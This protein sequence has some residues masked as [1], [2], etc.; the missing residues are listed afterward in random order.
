MFIALISD[1][2]P[3]AF[4]SIL[5]KHEGLKKKNRKGHD[6]ILRRNNIFEGRT[7]DYLK[8]A[9]AIA[10][11]HEGLLMGARG[12]L[13]GWLDAYIRLCLAKP[14]MRFQI[15]RLQRFSI[16]AHNLSLSNFLF[17][18][19]HCKLSLK[20]SLPRKRETSHPSSTTALES[21]K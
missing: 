21:L 9:Q 11:E 13:R 16:P 7:S 2:L 10:S 15:S 8:G 12:A 3:H 6:W 5:R 1:E 20:F 17:E 19:P 18:P 14:P 4:P